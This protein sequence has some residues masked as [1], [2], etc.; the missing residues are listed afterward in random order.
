[1]RELSLGEYIKQERI[2]Q[3]I[4]QEQLCEGIC[5]PITISRMENGK[6]I[7]SYTRIRTFL[8]RL[9]L[10]DNQYFALLSQNELK[11]KTLHDEILADAILFE[12]SGPEDRSKIRETGMQKLAAF[13]KL[14]KPDDGIIHQYILAMKGTFG[15]P[16]EPYSPKERLELLWEALHITVPNCDIEE[17][18]HGLYSLDEI[19]LILQIGNI[20]T[21]L[22]QPNKSIDIYRQLFKYAQKHY[23]KPAQ[24]AGKFALIAHNYT[25]TLFNA[26]RYD[27]AIDV[28]EQGRKI[29]VKYTHYQF[30]PGLLD[31][32]GGCY[33]YKRELE[34]CK[35]YYRT[36]HCLYK[37]TGNDRDRV[38]LEEAAKRRLN[39]KFPFNHSNY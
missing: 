23:H 20:Y 19:S 5:E 14:A 4:T 35:E 37:I 18:N 32:L 13:G 30:L 9:S 7:P 26:G 2:K 29:C 25:K 34:K 28:A 22:G 27:D 11:T 15:K 36:A 33:F 6:Q 10:L 17:I 1:M 39:Q 3:G 8:Q 38:L 31:F 12:H 16:G 21:K 24:Y